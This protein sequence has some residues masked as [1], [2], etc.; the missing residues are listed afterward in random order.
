MEF[1]SGQEARDLGLVRVGNRALVFSQ[2]LDPVVTVD[3]QGR[4]V[5]LVSRGRTFHRGLDGSWLEKTLT[6]GGLPV[7]RAVRTSSEI[8]SL[9]ERACATITVL[10]GNA[11]SGR[12]GTAIHGTGD[13][14]ERQL[15]TW[16]EQRPIATPADHATDALRFRQVYDPV[17]I[18][19][20]DQYRAVVLEAASGCPWNACR[21][22]TLYERQTYRV[23][24]GDE[25]CKHTARVIEFLGGG[26]SFRRSVFLGGGSVAR[27]MPETLAERARSARRMLREAG[28]TEEWTFHAFADAFTPSAWPPAALARLRAEGF[29]RFHIGVESGC[30]ALLEAVRKPQTCRHVTELIMNLKAAGLAV[31]CILLT[32]L[33]GQRFAE[34][35]VRET[36]ELIHHLPLSAQDIVYLSPFTSE[37]PT[38]LVDDSLIEPL[39][40]DALRGQEARLRDG[41]LS[42]R[43]SR[44]FQVARYD[45]RQF[46]Y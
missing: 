34:D 39:S 8:A 28:S 44:G 40:P 16:L 4:V 6:E 14:P 29:R 3:W 41:L 15:Q 38:R 12:S 25:F 1:A 35:H 31:G 20:P 33:G 27:L 46:V 7:A 22:C 32:G 37:N 30:Q 9:L 24:S 45:L 5:Y 43:R 11:L 42:L 19:P 2:G 36:L 21:F 17:P 10:G 18:L 23:R 26:L 13:S